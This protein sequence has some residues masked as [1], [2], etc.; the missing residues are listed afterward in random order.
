MIR[1]EE[2][3]AIGTDYERLSTEM[4]SDAAIVHQ[5][6]WVREMYTWD[7]AVAMHPEIH[8]KLLKPPHSTLMCQPPFDV[9]LNN[10]GV[11]QGM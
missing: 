2:W 5:L 4:E 6:A 11:V 8:I 1:H 7:V 9:A 3:L 10:V